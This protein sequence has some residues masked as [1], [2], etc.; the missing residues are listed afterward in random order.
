MSRPEYLTRKQEQFVREYLVDFNATQAA[1]RAGYAVRSA[2]S[3]GSELLKNPRVKY[4]IETGTMLRGAASRSDVCFTCTF[5]DNATETCRAKVP[6][7]GA[8]GRAAWPK[9]GPVDWC[10]EG[11]WGTASVPVADDPPSLR[12]VGDD[13]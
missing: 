13:F 9:V 6:S 8:D 1:I 3:I 5:C 11:D 2:G 10:S 12:V 7:I 4:E